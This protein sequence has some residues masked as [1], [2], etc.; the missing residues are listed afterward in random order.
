MIF[1]KRCDAYFLHSVTPWRAAADMFCACCVSAL[2][3]SFLCLPGQVSG[4]RSPV[5]GASAVLWGVL[6]RGL[7]GGSVHPASVRGQPE[8]PKGESSVT[9]WL[10]TSRQAATGVRALTVR[11]DVYSTALQQQLLA[12]LFCYIQQSLRGPGERKKDEPIYILVPDIIPGIYH[13][14]ADS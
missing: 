5:R 10:H 7:D 11:E 13:K 1:G 9:A 2:L 6:V 4:R 14:V 12:M 3:A 8:D